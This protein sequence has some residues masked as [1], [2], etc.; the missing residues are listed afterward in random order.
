MCLLTKCCPGVK[1]P[2]F[3]AGKQRDARILRDLKPEVFEDI[4]ALVALYRPGPLGSGMVED[5]VKNKHGIK[6]INYLNA[7]LEPILKDTY[8]VILYQEQVMR[9]QVTWQDFP[10]VRP[11]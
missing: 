7:K 4:V 8:G 10:W 3:S 5:F 2:G 6:K 1:P 9:I 11:I